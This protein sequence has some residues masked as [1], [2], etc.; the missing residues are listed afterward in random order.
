MTSVGG[1]ANNVCLVS[2]PH[3]PSKTYVEVITFL[4]F[5]V[6]YV[7]QSVANLHELRRTY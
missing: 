7:L 3:K 5:S 1:P 4:V 6:L 2:L